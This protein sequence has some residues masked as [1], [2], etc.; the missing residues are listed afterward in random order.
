MLGLNE[1]DPSVTSARSFSA[2]DG[3]LQALMLYTDGPYLLARSIRR[4]NPGTSDRDRECMYT[5]IDL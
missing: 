2:Q 5:K 3:L 4:L 1:A